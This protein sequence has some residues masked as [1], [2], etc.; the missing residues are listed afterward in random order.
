MLRHIP[1]I[2]VCLIL[3]PACADF[4]PVVEVSADGIGGRPTETRT[5][6][7]DFNTADPTSLVVD[8]ADDPDTILPCSPH[9]NDCT[10]RSAITLAN[11]EDS[12]VTSILFASDY[13]IQ[14]QS[15]LPTI[16]AN[17][18]M[19]QTQLGQE[20]NIN[21]NNLPSNVLR[22]TGSNTVIDGLR[23]YGSGAGFSNLW[24]GG[25]ATN[26]IIANNIIGD[27]DAPSGD[28]GLSDQS[29]GGIFIDAKEEGTNNTKVWIY[30]NII[31]CHR[32]QPGEGITIAT[33]GVFIGE[34]E[35]G[36]ANVQQKNEIRE[37]AGF[38]IWIGDYGGNTVRNTIIE[39]NGGSFFVNNFNNNLLEN[40]IR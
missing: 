30:N 15:P 25:A 29:Y 40:E 33:S 36:R 7:T 9:P 38:A 3:L 18:L 21:G 4:E 24:I 32:G 10:L 28:C 20:V 34:N 1:F 35:Q 16:S 23:L 6:G 12:T 17:N 26:V 22:I 19:L 8:R 27:D 13:R 31:E 39:G 37:N 5:V 2:L 14:L 11:R